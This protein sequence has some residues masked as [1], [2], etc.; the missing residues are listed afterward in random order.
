MVALR[1]HILHLADQHFGPN[2]V[3][4]SLKWNQPSF[5]IIKPKRGTTLRMD[6]DGAGSLSLYF[7][8]TSGL[9]D[10]FR[11]LYDDELT[12]VGNRELRLGEQFQPNAAIDHC[13]LLALDPY[14]KG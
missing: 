2:R 12:L 6:A 11:N 7:T 4:E 14:T 10:R 13:I 9:V 3:M 8:C 5:N 1:Q